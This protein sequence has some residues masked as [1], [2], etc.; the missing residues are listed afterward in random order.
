MSE[1]V[2]GPPQLTLAAALQSGF[3][4][5]TRRIWLL[6]L[7][8]ALDGFLWLGPRLSIR[9]LLHELVGLLEATPPPAGT[10]NPATIEVLREFSELYNLFG[11]LSPPFLGIPT[12]FQGADLELMP[13]T[14]HIIEIDSWAVFL[15]LYLLFSAIGI[16]AGALYFA[17]IARAAQPPAPASWHYW[18]HF[19]LRLLHFLGFALVL[20]L[21]ATILAVPT[22]FIA[23]LFSVVSLGLAQLV[24]ALAVGL[25]ITAVVFLFYG[26]HG[27]LYSGQTFWHA[28]Y[29][30][31]RLVRAHAQLT[32]WQLVMLVGIGYLLDVIWRVIEDGSWFT[33]VPIF[34]HA[35]VQ[36][37]ILVASVYVYADRA[38]R[39]PIS[40]RPRLT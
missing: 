28:V 2:D 32:L 36:T 9:P 30:S 25:F 6:L 7:P 27:I 40:Q 22:M 26:L 18:R 23:A 29:D 37:S 10:E 33:I 19:P 14:P 15:L 20:L 3:E 5:T 4:L 13:L 11:Q 39:L 31:W 24:F 38:S 1:H 12:L 16:L 21:L 17:Q 35:F 8:L 34:A